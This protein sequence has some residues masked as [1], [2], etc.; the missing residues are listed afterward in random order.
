M[1]VP[2]YNVVILREGED[3]I[4]SLVHEIAHHAQHMERK[5]MSLGTLRT[6]FQ[7]KHMERE[8]LLMLPDDMVV[9]KELRELRTASDQKL[10]DDILADEVYAE[11]IADEKAARPNMAKLDPVADAKMIEDWFLAGSAA[12]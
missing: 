4:N 12:K 2:R 5:L 11:L 10:V 3:L 8:I 9:G 7:A 6:E 1:Y